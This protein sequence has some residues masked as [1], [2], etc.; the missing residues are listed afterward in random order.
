MWGAGPFNTYNDD[1]S[2]YFADGAD[3]LWGSSTVLS[4]IGTAGRRGE[5]VLQTGFLLDR[6]GIQGRSGSGCQE[7]GCY[8]PC[9]QVC[10]APKTG[11]LLIAR[12]GNPVC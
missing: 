11:E 7:R 10:G 5:A 3:D 4:E 1:R 6:A 12:P 8:A 2:F 9:L